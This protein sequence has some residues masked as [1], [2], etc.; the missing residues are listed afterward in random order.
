MRSV[1]SVVS[2]VRQAKEVDRS[3][4][5]SSDWKAIKTPPRGVC[6]WVS[7]CV[8]RILWPCWET[9][10]QTAAEATTSAILLPLSLSPPLLLLFSFIFGSALESLAWCVC[11]ALHNNPKY[12][13]QPC[14]H[15][16]FKGERTKDNGNINTI[17]CA[18]LTS[19][20]QWVHH[21]LRPRTLNKQ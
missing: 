20:R 2:S 1:I 12:P 19:V 3:T 7:V 21:E 8:R 15:T 16:P 14:V 9:G 11:S 4:G 5:K 13:S 10:T 17:T 18:W 6:V